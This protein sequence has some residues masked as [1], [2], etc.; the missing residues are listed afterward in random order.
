MGSLGT[1]L[2]QDCNAMG[3]AA[4]I[5]PRIIS[6]HAQNAIRCLPI[7]HIIP[8]RQISVDINNSSLVPSV[9]CLPTSRYFWNYK[10]TANNVFP[11]KILQ[12]YGMAAGA[13]LTCTNF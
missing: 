1:R 12:S 11:T 13:I 3:E 10:R 9:S 2:H 4:K 6:T 7:I 5:S 8:S